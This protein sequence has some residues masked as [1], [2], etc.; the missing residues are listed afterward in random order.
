MRWWK[1]ISF[2]R[3]KGKSLLLNWKHDSYYVG[4]RKWIGD[5]NEKCFDKSNRE[6]GLGKF[7]ILYVCMCVCVREGER[8]RK[9]V[10]SHLQARLMDKNKTK[11]NIDVHVQPQYLAVSVWGFSN[12][13]SYHSSAFY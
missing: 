2:I 6:T 10:L 4:I 3:Q 7:L 8:E 1:K 9:M 12:W 11:F 13:D 5:N